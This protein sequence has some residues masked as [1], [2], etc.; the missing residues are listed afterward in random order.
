MGICI[1]KDEGFAVIWWIG[2]GLAWGGPLP[3]WCMP[4]AKLRVFGCLACEVC[5]EFGCLACEIA[6]FW[7]P[8]VRGI[9]PCEVC[10]I[11]KIHMIFYVY[12]PSF[13]VVINSEKAKVGRC[14]HP[15]YKGVAKMSPK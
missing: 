8:C 5:V 11:S 12:L 3:S 6:C 10:V 14:V 7:V 4:F 2:E 15:I 13:M 1:R 9:P